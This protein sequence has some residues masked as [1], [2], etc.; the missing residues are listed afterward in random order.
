MY[1]GIKLTQNAVLIF[2]F[3]RNW[4][5]ARVSECIFNDFRLFHKCRVTEFSIINFDSRMKLY[6]KY[7]FEEGK[8]I[9]N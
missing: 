9:F 8:R 1:I 7:I 6:V 5:M 2:V 4:N 3:I